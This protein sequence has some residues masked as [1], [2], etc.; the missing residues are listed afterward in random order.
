[1]YKLSSW[2][3]LEKLDW[4]RLSSNENAIHILEKNIDKLVLFIIKC[5]CCIYITK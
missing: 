5:K 4:D 3:P 1:M 2:V